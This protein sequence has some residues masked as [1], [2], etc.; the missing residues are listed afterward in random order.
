MRYRLYKFLKYKVFKIKEGQ[1]LPKYLL[2]IKCLLF[3][4]E[5]IK[6]FGS[7][8]IYDVYRDV[9]TI[10]G[11]KVCS[12]FFEASKI[13]GNKFEIIKLDNGIVTVKEFK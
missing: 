6:W 2:G 13:I 10:R 7:K 1:I 8:N 12:D 4:I 5:A 11:V 3:P 9:Y